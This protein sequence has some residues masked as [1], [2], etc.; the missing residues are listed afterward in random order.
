MPL[1]VHPMG[2]LVISPEGAYELE[3]DA[4]GATVERPCRVSRPFAASTMAE[5]RATGRP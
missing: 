2:M 5:R 1:P 4:G 3:R